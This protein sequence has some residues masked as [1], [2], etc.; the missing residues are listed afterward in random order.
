M[1]QIWH[2]FSMQ[3]M[4]INMNFDV[5]SITGESKVKVEEREKKMCKQI[6]RKQR[7]FHRLRTAA[8]QLSSRM[9]SDVFSE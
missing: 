1:C 5:D 9:K 7:L 6:A 3:P 4:V 2:V 8:S